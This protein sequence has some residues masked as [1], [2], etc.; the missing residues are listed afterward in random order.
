MDVA[1]GGPDETTQAIRE[2]RRVTG[3]ALQFWEA[4]RGPR[5]YPSRGDIG[6][7]TPAEL[8]PH[9]FLVAPGGAEG[10]CAFAEGGSVL[11]ALCGCDPVG[12]PVVDALPAELR[13]RAA[14]L[15]A[16]AFEVGKPLADSGSFAEDRETQVLYRAVFMPLSSDQRRVDSLLGAISFKRTAL[17]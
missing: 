16:A 11:G 8:V 9:L 12:Q 14:A 2:P 4:V 5:P 6:A 7:R 3:K 15:M 1:L 13:S 17:H 10:L